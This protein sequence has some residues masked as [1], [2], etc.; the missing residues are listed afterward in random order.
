MDKRYSA[1]PRAIREEVDRVPQDEVDAVVAVREALGYVRH[2]EQKHQDFQNRRAQHQQR[3][4]AVTDATDRIDAE[5]IAIDSARVALASRI[6]EG[7]TSADAE[8]RQERARRAD[9]LRQRE[10]LGIAAEGLHAT[11]PGSNPYAEACNRAAEQLEAARW[12]ARV[13]LATAMAAH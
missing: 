5:V 4:A 13:A 6:A 9:L 1:L 3:V 2:L 10:L 11:A 7:D 12:D 8:D